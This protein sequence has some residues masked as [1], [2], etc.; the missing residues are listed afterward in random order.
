MALVAEELDPA[1]LQPGQ[2]PRIVEIV[3][4]LVAAIEDRLRVELSGDRLGDSGH[5]PRLAEQVRWSQQRLRGH[6]GVVGAL[7]ADKVLLDDRH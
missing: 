3:D 5:P 6:A 7:A 4:H 1:F 2:L